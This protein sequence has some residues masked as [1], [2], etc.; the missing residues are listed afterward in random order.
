MSAT[1][2]IVGN[3]N[4]PVAKGMGIVDFATPADA[5]KAEEG[6]N[7]KVLFGRR[8]YLQFDDRRGE[9][10]SGKPREQRGRDRDRSHRR[11]PRDSAP[12][13]KRSPDYSDYSDDDY[14]YALLPLMITGTTAGEERATV[15]RDWIGTI[16]DDQGVIST[17]GTRPGD[18]GPTEAQAIII[19]QIKSNSSFSSQ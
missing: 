19:T 3:L 7:E 12:R 16:K 5:E 18:R 15:T 6:L 4:Y 14:R 9:D 10:S 8:C 1:R 2:L 11:R 13:R 17:I